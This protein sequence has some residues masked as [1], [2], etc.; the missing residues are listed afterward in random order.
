[1]KVFSILAALVLV[2]PAIGSAQTP[3]AM[4]DLTGYTRFVV[5]PHLQQAWGALERGDRTRA[6]SEFERARSLAPDSASVAL[7][8]ASA[9]QRFGDL[10][11]AESLLR[12][13]ITL[14]PGDARLLP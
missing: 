2:V 6:L 7:Q 9:Y 4:D 13:Q 12:A 14:T 5:Y 3:A 1:M 11:K 8:L 10:G